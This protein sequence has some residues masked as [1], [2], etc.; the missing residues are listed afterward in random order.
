MTSK[1]SVGEKLQLY[2]TWSILENNQCKN[3]K[4]KQCIPAYKEVCEVKTRTLCKT[5]N[6]KKCRYPVLDYFVMN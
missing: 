2:Y 3:F 1:L 4:V 6:V 5:S